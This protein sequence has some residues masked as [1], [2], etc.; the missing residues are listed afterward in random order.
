MMKFNFIIS[1][2]SGPSRGIA[3]RRP[4]N[5]NENGPKGRFRSIRFA[6]PVRRPTPARLPASS[7][8]VPRGTRFRWLRRGLF[9]FFR[10]RPRGLLLFLLLHRGF[11]RRLLR[12]RFFL[13]AAAFFSSAGRYSMI[14]ISA[15]SPTGN[16]SGRSGYSRPAGDESARQR[17]E[18]LV[19]ASLS[20]RRE[21]TRRREWSVPAFRE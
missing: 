3:G 6:F 19:V 7:A 12:G 20:V 15:P 10:W 2:G 17:G 1:P 18:E 5:R 4:G 8:S 21:K 13:F 16:R 9:H 14:A 11:C